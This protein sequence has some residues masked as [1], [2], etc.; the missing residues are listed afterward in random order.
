MLIKGRT[1]CGAVSSRLVFLCLRSKCMTCCFLC[2]CIC[3]LGYYTERVVVSAQFI[4]F[5]SYS[6]VGGAFSTLSVK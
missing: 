3:L 4:K 6:K 5:K 1:E 2:V